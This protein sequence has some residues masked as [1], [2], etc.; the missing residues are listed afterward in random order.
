MINLGEEKRRSLLQGFGFQEDEILISK[1]KKD[2]SHLKKEIIINK[3]GHQQTVWIETEQEITPEF[4]TQVQSIIDSGAKNSDKIRAFMTMGITD[5]NSL[6]LLTGA[7]YAQV[8][9]LVTKGVQSGASVNIQTHKVTVEDSVVTIKPENKPAVKVELPRPDVEE[10]WENYENGADMVI[11]G[12]WRSLIIYGRGGVGKTFTIE[13]TLEASRKNGIPLRP[14]KEE[15]DESYSMSIASFIEENRK[16]TDDEDNEMSS[17]DEDIYEEDE[18][19]S[20]G[21]DKKPN[22]KGVKGIQLAISHFNTYKNN[23][24]FIAA[25]KIAKEASNKNGLDKAKFVEF[26][27]QSDYDYVFIKG[28]ASTPAVFASLWQHNRK[29]I[30]FDDCDTALT[31]QETQNYLKSAL[32]TNGDNVLTGSSK[33]KSENGMKVPGRYPFKG[34]V[35]FISNLPANKMEQALKSRAL[36]MDMTMTK[37]ET[38]ERMA[39]IAPKMSYKNADTKEKIPISDAA[40]SAVL[41]LFAEYKDAI[42]I[43][44]FNT[45]NIV[46]LALAYDH[47]ANRGQDAERWKRQ[48]IHLLG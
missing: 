25:E 12:D 19:E 18:E 39:K 23:K 14:F 40:K 41:A 34:K 30:I 7:T 33:N 3:L 36:C 43:D 42:N 37:D 1:A 6:V 31:Y 21:K 24:D 10:M 29:T 16:V 22:Y 26:A 20:S 9:G 15:N 11:N 46:K 17:S 8:H 48:A 2:L 45:R 32:D 27:K 28:K 4:Q 44:H 5:K 35:I 13:K 47:S 38:L